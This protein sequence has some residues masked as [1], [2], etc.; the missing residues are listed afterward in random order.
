LLVIQWNRD[1]TDTGRFAHSI[2]PRVSLRPRFDGQGEDRKFVSTVS[3][4]M[5]CHCTARSHLSRF[6]IDEEAM[7]V[8]LK[9][10]TICYGTSKDLRPRGV[11]WPMHSLHWMCSVGLLSG[12]CVLWR[13][14][15]SA[16]WISSEILELE[17]L[18]WLSF[19]KDS[20]SNITSDLKWLRPVVLVIVKHAIF[21]K[22]RNIYHAITKTW[23]S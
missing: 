13:S 3:R 21:E 7:C 20:W 11:I 12:I 4:V 5:S 14:E 15:G 10:W 9:Q 23:L 2:L 17:L 22:K 18:T 6:G 16:V 1:A 8:C 19:F